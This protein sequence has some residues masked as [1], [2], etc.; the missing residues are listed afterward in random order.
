M[1]YIIISNPTQQRITSPSSAAPTFSS[2]HPFSPQS[3]HFSY[4]HSLKEAEKILK[5]ELQA[6]G[7]RTPGQ[8]PENALGEIENLILGAAGNGDAT[9]LSEGYSRLA[10]WV[11]ASLDAVRP[12]LSRVLLPVFVHTYLNL[13]S[14][15]AI[16]EAQEL[17]SLHGE[18]FTDIPAQARQIAQLSTISLPE[19]LESSRAA[20]ALKNKRH[21]VKMTAPSADLL[22]RFLRTDKR[23]LPLLSITNNHVELMLLEELPLGMGNGLLLLGEDGSVEGD[24]GGLLF[25]DVDDEFKQAVIAEAAGVN[26][27][28][29]DLRLLA[30][31]LEDAYFADVA[32]REEK[33]AQEKAD[34][35]D[36]INKKQKKE[37]QKASDDARARKEAV[38]AD[39]RPA[40][41]IPL[42]PG[43]VVAPSD[44][45]ELRSAQF[46]TLKARA[47]VSP[48]DPPS[49]AFYT[50][51]N[52]NQT[53][54]SAV[55]FSQDGSLVAAGFDDASVRLYN[56]KAAQ[57]S[58]NGTTTDNTSLHN[59]G[60][61]FINTAPL[62]DQ[63]IN[64]DDEEV[65]L[66][67]AALSS[68]AS[69]PP[70]TFLHGHS[71]PVYGIDI[72]Q[73]EDSLLLSCSGDGTIR[74]WSLEMLKGG[75]SLVAYKG[76]MLPVWDVASCPRSGYYFASGG[77]DR[78]GRIWCTE[79]SKALRLLV[80][81]TSDVDVVKWHPGCHLVAT[82]SADTTVR[83]W[84][85]RTGGCVRLLAG[86]GGGGS[87]RVGG[88]TAMSFSP[89]G[90]QIVT[91]DSLGA[92]SCWDLGSAK[93]VS[94]GGGGN[95]SEKAAVW[96]LAHS[97][98]DGSVVASGGADCSVKLWSSSSSS[99]GTGGLSQFL[100]WQTKA[101]PVLGLRFSTLNLLLG[102]GPLALRKPQRL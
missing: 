58:L 51:L 3:S 84:D 20:V 63:H 66:A 80:G 89:N 93:R 81:H 11:D 75:G 94:T 5:L 8:K 40:P 13:V 31:G 91:G 55:A 56:M 99:S 48:T 74:L 62:A 46:A 47:T 73:P 67:S 21:V 45:K 70:V 22:S 41:E 12:E 39:R 23:L 14:L 52:T 26:A 82:G 42:P 100:T 76:H 65:T 54:S 83:V 6:K 90:M 10:A 85:V 64:E 78:A 15:G 69:G 32:E 2:P 53:L 7:S 97:S 96:S 61:T 17:K 4:I 25:M 16:E 1:T 30:G 60:H 92:V 77:A 68:S 101:T 37:F 86:G 57:S 29:V 98:G 49:C 34:K 72:M 36:N 59:N 33:E 24:D 19:H 18:R 87:G 28:A 43:F 88:V 102:G 79:R 9:V 44:E 71:A 38:G 35:D 95:R 27:K 50:F